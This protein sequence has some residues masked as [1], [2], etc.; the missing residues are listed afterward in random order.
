[1]V[2]EINLIISNWI[3]GILKEDDIEVKVVEFI[4]TL[5]VAL[6]C[7]K[8]EDATFFLTDKTDNEENGKVE[9]KVYKYQKNGREIEI[10]FD[11]IHGVKGE[12]HTAT[13]YIECFLR[14]FDIG[15]KVVKFISS[16][17]KGR[18]KL[19]K[20]DACKK[21]LP[22]AYVALTRA[23]HFFSIAIDKERFD[24]SYHEYFEANKDFWEV[25][26]L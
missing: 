5:L 18:V 11:T 26:H 23:T 14:I 19:R 8:N 22:M 20:E 4:D 7:A 1:M 9:N 3:I 24:Q 10:H 25:C 2:Q 12:T 13:L 17:E 6:G 21:Q 15:E 16:D